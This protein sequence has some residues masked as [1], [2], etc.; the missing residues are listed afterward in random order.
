MFGSLPTYASQVAQ[1]RCQ[2]VIAH[3]TVNRR[4]LLVS[5]SGVLLSTTVEQGAA[6]T[7]T[8]EAV[9]NADQAAVT[10]AAAQVSPAPVPKKPLRRKRKR[11]PA[12][13][14][15]KAALKTP[16]VIPTVKLG[17]DLE[18][19][20]VRRRQSQPATKADLRGT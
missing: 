2:R 17:K 11:P 7:E 18:I 10:E 19:S 14:K 12:A 1:C 6:A 3:S 4:D 15:Q 20:K 5:T 13:A 8:A 9:S 16:G